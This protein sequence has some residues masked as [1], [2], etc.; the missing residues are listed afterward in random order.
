MRTKSIVSVGLTILGLGALGSAWTNNEANADVYHRGTWYRSTSTVPAGSSINVQLNSKISTD[1][2]QPGDTWTGTV[3]QSVY[4]GN[5]VVIP[6]GS[7]V[8]GVISGLTQGTHQT[9]PQLSLA[10]REVNANGQTY[11][12]NA[13]TQPIVAGTNRARKLGVIAGSAAVG[14]L[15][16]HTVAKDKHGTLIG[17]LLG[18]AAGYG[19]SRNAMRTMQLKPGTVLTFT[20]RQQMAVR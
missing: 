4:A 1:S 12:L 7:P 10:L 11:A 3:T 20:S 8:T 17:G 13:D 14:A 18:G 9:R 15:V 16:G 6:A 5:R 19:V 2:N